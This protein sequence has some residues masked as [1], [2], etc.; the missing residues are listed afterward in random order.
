MTISFL[1]FYILYYIA[2]CD[3]FQ[4][5]F[6]NGVSSKETVFHNVKYGFFGSCVVHSVNGHIGKKLLTV[7]LFFLLDMIEHV[8]HA[9]VRKLKN[10]R[11]V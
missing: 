1:H 10:S 9:L 4:F 11:V 7:L 3:I 8:S 2:C 6:R 5:I